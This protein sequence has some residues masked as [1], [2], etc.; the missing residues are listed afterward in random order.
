MSYTWQVP[1]SNY[2]AG[3]QLDYSRRALA[4][5]NENDLNETA[6]IGGR[7]GIRVPVGPEPWVLA[8]ENGPVDWNRDGDT[9]DSN[10]SADINYIRLRSA[11]IQAPARRLPDTKTGR[12]WTMIFATALP[13]PTVSG[14]RMLFRT[15]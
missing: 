13:T 14:T 4:T 3:W 11:G 2:Q 6:G 7:S 8:S 10:V 1:T 9:N 5:L 15:S 12:I